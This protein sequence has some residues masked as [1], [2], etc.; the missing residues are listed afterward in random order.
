MA[1]RTGK[2]VW[3]G[4]LKTGDG[5]LEF[6]S[7]SA[8]YSFSSRFENGTGSNP[9]ELLAA[10]HA[11]CFSMALSNILS[12]DG[13]TPVSVETTAKVYLEVG[14]DGAE[15]ARI[16]LSCLAVV[17]IISEEKFHEHA[18]TAKVGCPISKALAA[19][20]INLNA[21]LQKS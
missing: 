7:F 8:P 21:S 4:D 9:D 11:S 1:I 2:A 3:R 19:T 16:D 5:K 14:S 15:I 18:N 17:P 13:F 12:T 10:A 20:P 6:G